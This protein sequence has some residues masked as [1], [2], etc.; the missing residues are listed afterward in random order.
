MGQKSIKILV[1]AA[2]SFEGA[3]RTPGQTL[4]VPE[5]LAKNLFE[6]GR[7]ELANGGEDVDK[8]LDE[9]TVAELRDLAKEYE[10]DGADKM[11]KPELIDAIEAA[12][13]D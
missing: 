1:T 8:P 5:D 13:D 3:I 4:T 9:M 11:K 10:I 2:F 7:A 12:E 6:R